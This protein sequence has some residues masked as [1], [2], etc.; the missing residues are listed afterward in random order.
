MDDLNLNLDFNLDLDLS[1]GFKSPD[2]E[3]RYVIP[4][5]IR[6]IKSSRVKYSNAE[7][8]VDDID[9]LRNGDRVF[10]VLAGSFIFGDLIEAYIVKHNIGVKEMTISTLSLSEENIDSLAN[11]INGGFVEKLNIIVSDY[12][13]SHEKHHLINYMYRELDVDNKF[14]LAVARVHTKITMFETDDQLKHV[15]YGSANLRSSDN[16]EQLVM[17]VSN[18]LYDF[19]YQWHQLLLDEFSTIKKSI[20]GK[21]LWQTVATEEVEEVERQ[22]DALQRKNNR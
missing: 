4:K 22:K 7:K 11:L 6:G 12:F 10:S 1:G 2:V 16:I 5:K 20:G 8:L 3:T 13:Y 14:Q 18:E 15:W 19:N 17:E 21:K 9:E